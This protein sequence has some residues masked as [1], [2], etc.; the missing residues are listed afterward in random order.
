MHCLISFNSHCYPRSYF[1]PFSTFEHGQNGCS[2]SCRWDSFRCFSTCQHS[3]QYWTSVG[4]L[5]HK[6]L[7]ISFSCLHHVRCD[8]EGQMEVI[9]AMFCS[10]GIEPLVQK[11]HRNNYQMFPGLNSSQALHTK[12][13]LFTI[14]AWPSVRTGSMT[15]SI[16]LRVLLSPSSA[17]FRLW[18]I[19]FSV[20]WVVSRV[21]IGISV[22]FVCYLV[23]TFVLFDYGYHQHRGTYGLFSNNTIGWYQCHSSS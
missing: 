22:P 1:Q 15:K 12:D 23:N 13:P 17:C 9:M 7:T 14:V 6:C 20:S 5:W 4:K 10:F 3:I 8:I 18:G 11:W 2:P 21:P 16:R 19:D